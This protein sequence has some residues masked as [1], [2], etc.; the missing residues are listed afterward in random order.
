MGNPLIENLWAKDKAVR[1]KA[2]VAFAEDLMTKNILKTT[3]DKLDKLQ[4][5]YEA[6]LGKYSSLADRHAELAD[7][8]VSAMTEVT[9]VEGDATEGTFELTL[10]TS[11][12][13][14]DTN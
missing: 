13:Y 1:E 9:K 11:M 10:P 8:Y 7:K 2:E 3:M 12:W 14:P 4:T 6:M 5:R